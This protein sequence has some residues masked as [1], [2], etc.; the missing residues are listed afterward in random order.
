MLVEF[1]GG[2]NVFCAVRC[3]L[4]SSVSP[5]ESICVCVVCVVPGNPATSQSDN[6]L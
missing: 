2:E 3:R 6:I 5:K 1:V 4:C